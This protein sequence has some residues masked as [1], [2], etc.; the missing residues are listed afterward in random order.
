M[1]N[2]GGCHG[3]G[4]EGPIWGGLHGLWREKDRGRGLDPAA[5]QTPAG[6]PFPVAAGNTASAKPGSRT[7]G[8]ALTPAVPRRP[9]EGLLSKRQPSVEFFITSPNAGPLPGGLC[10]AFHHT[11]SGQLLLS[12]PFT[13]GREGRCGQH[14]QLGACLSHTLLLLPHPRQWLRLDPPP[15]SRRPGGSLLL[16][17]L[18]APGSLSAAVFPAT[19]RGSQDASSYSCTRRLQPIWLL[20]KPVSQG[21]VTQAA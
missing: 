15:P 11:V 7:Q 5:P 6:A 20:C 13:R 8:W 10:P 1:A 16:L 2:W 21:F 19:G 4:R 14:H 17:P 3:G 12:G 18:P 9:R